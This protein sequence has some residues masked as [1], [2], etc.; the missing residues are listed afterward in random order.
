MLYPDHVNSA[1][2]ET[3]YARY[4]RRPLLDLSVGT[5]RR[6]GRSVCRD[7]HIW[8][9][10]NRSGIRRCAVGNG[11]GYTPMLAMARHRAGAVAAGT[12]GRSVNDRRFS[13]TEG[14]RSYVRTRHWTE[15]RPRSARLLRDAV[16][17]PPRRNRPTGCTGRPG[18]A[19]TS[20]ASTK[21]TN[22]GTPRP[23]QHHD[24]NE[25]QPP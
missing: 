12:T 3:P 5:P 14:Q 4:A 24:H 13:Y 18:E 9:G 25:L 21:L 11:C 23:A 22:A 6:T 17:P 16:I 20:T 10:S 7:D 1:Y 2:V 19:A 8:E 15:G